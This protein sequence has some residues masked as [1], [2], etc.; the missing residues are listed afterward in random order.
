[1]CALVAPGSGVRGR[2]TRAL[3]Y[4]GELELSAA[5]IE[6]I[7]RALQAQDAEEAL[8]QLAREMKTEGLGQREMYHLFEAQLLHRRSDSDES[9]YDALANTMDRIVGWCHPAQRLFETEL[10]L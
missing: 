8:V 10:Q 3:G 9:A 2:S 1:V 7:E 5:Q 6:R 4:T